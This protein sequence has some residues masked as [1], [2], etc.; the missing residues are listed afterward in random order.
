VEL[1]ARGKGQCISHVKRAGWNPL[2]TPVLF[3][4]CAWVDR[5]TM[6]IIAKNFC[7][8]KRERHGNRPVMLF[9]DNLD[10]HCWEEDLNEFAR[11][12]VL[13]VFVVPGCTDA[14]QPIDAGIGQSIRIYIGQELD[15][16]LMVND[17]LDKWESRPP[18]SRVGLVLVT[19]LVPH[20]K[21]QIQSHINSHKRKIIHSQIIPMETK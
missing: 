17:N 6:L 2:V 8:K 15:A 7:I 20:K 13:V 16:W 12:N 3:Q 1:I 21:I 11:A 19:D 14:I 9:A 4:K 5:P 10:A 18:R